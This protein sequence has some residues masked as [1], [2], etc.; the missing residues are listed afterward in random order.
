[1]RPGSTASAPSARSSC[2]TISSNPRAQGATNLIVRVILR[3]M[4]MR[5]LGAA[6]VKVSTLCLGAM[7]FGDVDE[8]SMM[9]K[10]SCD[11]ETALALMDRALAAGINFFDTADVY[12][13]NGLSE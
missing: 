2:A 9:H 13:P 12:G 4:E 8:R 3:R 7:T 1:M 11:E 6:G 10:A 5:N